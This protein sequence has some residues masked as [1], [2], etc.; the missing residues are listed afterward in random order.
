[1]IFFHCIYVAEGVGNTTTDGEK[2]RLSPGCF[3]ITGPEML[4]S[5]ETDE[6]TVLKLM[7]VKFK[8]NDEKLQEKIMSFPKMV[9][10][11]DTP[12][13]TILKRICLEIAEKK[14]LYS[15]ITALNMREI[16]TIIE[17][18]IISKEGEIKKG[19]NVEKESFSD[20]ISYIHVNLRKDIELQDLADCMRLE[21]SYFLK[22]V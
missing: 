5:F 2:Y 11:A 6:N 19:S 14:V 1:M 16:L 7:E 4:H 22:K 18:K 9:N 17:R 8:I 10:V 15:E 21:K 20:V 3:C 13:Y 12:I